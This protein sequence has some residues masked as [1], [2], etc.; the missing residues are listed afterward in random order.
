[1]HPILSVLLYIF[2]VASCKFYYLNCHPSVINTSFQYLRH[3]LIFRIGRNISS[4][5]LNAINSLRTLHSIRKHS[6]YNDR[7]NVIL[8]RK[9]LLQKLA[10]K[11]SRAAL[12]DKA[13]HINLDCRESN[14]NAIL[15][16]AERTSTVFIRLEHFYYL[17]CS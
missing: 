10:N 6:L 16:S 12:G 5:T 17:L 11:I 15:A 8:N 9:F 4:L 1:M 2:S 14:R 13:I 3:K 7:I